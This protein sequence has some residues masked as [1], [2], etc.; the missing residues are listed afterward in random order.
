MAV[1]FYDQAGSLVT[2]YGTTNLYAPGGLIQFTLDQ[3]VTG[4]EGRYNLILSAA[5]SGNT[6]KFGPL[7]TLVRPF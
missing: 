5:G 1:N 7:Q 3:V 2:S 6:I 4:N